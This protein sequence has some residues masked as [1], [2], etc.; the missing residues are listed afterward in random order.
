MPN[1]VAARR[2]RPVHERGCGD[3]LARGAEAALERVCADERVHEP[4]VAQ[5]LDR[6]HFTLADRL[7][8]RDARERGRAVEEDSARAAMALAAGDLRPRQ[9]EIVADRLGKRLQD[10]AV[11]R[12]AATVDDELNQRPPSA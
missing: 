5:A 9:A 4:V 12:V 3:D 2:G 8:E 6:R 1:L 11:D 10:G 7:R